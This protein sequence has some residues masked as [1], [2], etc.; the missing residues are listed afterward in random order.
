MNDAT[1]KILLLQETASN[2]ADAHA[3]EAALRA[4]GADV[5][6]AQL[7]P[8]YEA[9]L[10]ALADGWTPLLLPPSPSTPR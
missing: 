2:P 10:D 8:P 7:S 5:R 3:L 4:E 9:L 6:R 1:R